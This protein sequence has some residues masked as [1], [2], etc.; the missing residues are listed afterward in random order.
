MNS[1]LKHIVI[2]F[3]ALLFYGCSDKDELV[4]KQSTGTKLISIEFFPT[5][6]KYGRNWSYNYYYSNNG[7]LKKVH[8]SSSSGLGR[9][10]EIEYDEDGRIKQYFTYDLNEN[11]LIF[12]D[13]IAYNLNGTIQAIHHFSINLG[14]DLPLS[15]ITE[16]EYNDENRIIKKSSF[17]VKTQEYLFSEKYYWGKDNIERVKHYGHP[18]KDGA[19]IKAGELHYEYFYKYDDKVNFRKKNNPVYI[20]DPINWSNNNVIEFEW[21][22]Y[23]GNLDLP[24]RP[25]KTEYKYNLDDHPVSVKYH[26]ATLKLTYE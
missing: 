10:Y 8:Q 15:D 26:W 2:P 5:E 7:K 19:F 23:L 17:L 20:D 18:N 25:C 16:Y 22:D 1:T 21:N 6:V 11:K 9:N 4:I 14:K 24:C 12:R 3:I 13:S